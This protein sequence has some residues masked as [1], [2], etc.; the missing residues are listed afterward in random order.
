MVII[1]MDDLH[2][3][4]KACEQ[5]ATLFQHVMPMAMENL[6]IAQ[7]Y[8]TLHYVIIHGG[9]YWPWV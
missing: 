4:I 3:W 5:Q 8:D 1:N 2:V 6:A 9:G 7:H